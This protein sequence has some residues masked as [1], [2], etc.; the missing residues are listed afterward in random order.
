MTGVRSTRGCKHEGG[1]STVDN[2]RSTIHF[3]PT[4]EHASKRAAL[5]QCAVV[6]LSDTRTRET[7]S[8]GK[9]II[10]RLEAAGHAVVDYEVLP[11][12]PVRVRAHVERLCASAC[13]AVLMT[14]G[15]GLS[16]R[17]T[18]YEAVSPLFEKRLG[19]FGEL[20]R[21]LSFDEIGATAMLSRAVAGVRNGTVVFAMPGSTDAVRLAMERLIL[22]SLGHIIDLISD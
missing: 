21:M 20:F 1:E 2:R 15:T 10:E 11:D 12:D 3:M 13:E 7:D 6:T 5:V 19:G 14:G 9:L 18:A 8:S 17:D 4:H 22:P 16:M